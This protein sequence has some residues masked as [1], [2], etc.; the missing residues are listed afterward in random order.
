MTDKAGWLLKQG[1]SHWNKRWLVLEGKYLKCYLRQPTD[2]KKKK[3]LRT[4]TIC[5]DIY[6]RV[7]ETKEYANREFAFCVQTKLLDW[8]LL[9]ESAEDTAEWIQIISHNI[10]EMRRQLWILERVLWIGFYK[11]NSDNCLIAALPKD[12]VRIILSYARNTLK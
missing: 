11:N 1:V 6:S 10:T 3:H 2:H 5:L 4:G 8:I 9:G 12:L 7:T